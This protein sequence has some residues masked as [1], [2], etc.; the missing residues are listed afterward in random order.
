MKTLIRNN[1]KKNNEKSR[2]MK[3]SIDGREWV[4]N[5]SW[6]DWVLK[7]RM[8]EEAE[9]KTDVKLESEMSW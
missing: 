1:N 8:E 9:L 7:E 4:Y 3:Q 2:Y 6:L 5:E